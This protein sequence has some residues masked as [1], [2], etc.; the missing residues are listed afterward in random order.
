MPADGCR[1]RNVRP[2]RP[3]RKGALR[4]AIRRGM[5][6]VIRGLV[7]ERESAAVARVSH[8]GREF[9]ALVD[10][11]ASTLTKA[12]G[13]SLI[14]EISFDRVVSWRLLPDFD[15]EDSCIMASDDAAEVL[16]VRGRVHSVLRVD[17][18]TEVLD[19]YLR[20]GPQFLAVD[21]TELGGSSPAIGS[22]I[23]LLLEGMCFYPTR[24]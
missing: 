18:V 2:R 24:T 23:E 4:S 8:G 16:V 12:L 15:D 22:G 11:S 10:G 20:T 6:I 21:S 9:V 13:Q 3:H 1:P 5:A 7:E 14:V 19:V 17:E